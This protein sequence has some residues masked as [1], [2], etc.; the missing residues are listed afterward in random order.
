[1]TP[2]PPPP[3]PLPPPH[4]RHCHHLLL[5]CPAPPSCSPA[6]SGQLIN[7]II[8]TYTYPRLDINVSKGMNHLLKSPWCAHP[9]TGRV[10][11]PVDADKPEQFD[12]SAVPTLRMVAEDLDA[13]MATSDGAPPTTRLTEAEGVFDAFLKKLENQIRGEKARE[14]K[15]RSEEALE[16]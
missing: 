5:T 3:P 1:M 11:V 8:F 6:K 16:F 4:H 2:P 9:K 10:C 14:A 15:K 13:A 7:E 12:P